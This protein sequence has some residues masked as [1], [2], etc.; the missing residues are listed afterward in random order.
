MDLV[1]GHESLENMAKDVGIVDKPK[2]LVTEG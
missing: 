2:N 1:L